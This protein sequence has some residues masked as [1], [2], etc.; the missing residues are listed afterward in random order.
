MSF[1]ESLEDLNIG[2]GMDESKCIMQDFTFAGH[3]VFREFTRLVAR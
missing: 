3:K 1:I 2:C